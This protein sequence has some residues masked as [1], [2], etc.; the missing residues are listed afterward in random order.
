LH[1]LNNI[2]VGYF[3]PEIVV[4][5]LERIYLPA[6]SQHRQQSENK[7][8]KFHREEYTAVSRKAPGVSAQQ[9]NLFI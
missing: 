6:H 2:V 7:K 9:W 4:S 1:K 3:E 8:T 5:N